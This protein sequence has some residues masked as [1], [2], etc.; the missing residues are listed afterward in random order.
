MEEIR[1]YLMFAVVP[2][3][4]VL[5][6]GAC[7]PANGDAP[8]TE[9]LSKNAQFREYWFGGTAELSRYR[10]EQARYGEL[11]SGEAV[12]I[13]VTEPFLKGKQVKYEGSWDGPGARDAIDVFKLNA[14]RKFFTGVYPYST[15]TST[16]TPVD[17]GPARRRALKITTGVQEWCGH[18][19]AQLNLRGGEYR[20]ASHSYFENE[21]DQKFSIPDHLTEDGLWALIRLQPAALPTG[22]LQILP[23]TQFLRMRHLPTR[24][25]AATAEVRDFN[26]ASDSLAT[27]GGLRVGA[28]ALRVYELVYAKPVERT[29][30]IAFEAEFPHSI[31]GWEELGVSGWGPSQ[32]A[33]TTR[34]VRTNVMQS[35]YWAKNSN[36]DAPLRAKLGVTAF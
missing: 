1:K 8:E 16:F 27:A 26:P 18:V 14:T 12:L 19:Y 15:M 10:L 22:R 2:L 13:F 17:Q 4:I 29:L 3:A 28:K 7:R 20:V 35:D 31:I 30:R 24:A 36:R 23:G 32:K 6:F 5:G 21:A 11:H 33:L 25:I 34:A 9:R